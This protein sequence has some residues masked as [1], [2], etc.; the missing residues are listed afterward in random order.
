MKLGTPA[1][2][3]TPF[4]KHKRPQQG[5]PSLAC[6]RLTQLTVEILDAFDCDL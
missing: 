4:I 3:S 2:W 6:G 1:M 5:L